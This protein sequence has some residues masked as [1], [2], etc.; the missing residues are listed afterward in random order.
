MLRGESLLVVNWWIDEIYNTHSDCRVHSGCIIILGKGVALN[1][2]PK[3]KLNVKRS[4]EWYLV[5]AHNGLSVV[6]WRNNFMEAQGCT[7]EQNNLY[8]YN[9]SNILM[10]K[11]GRAS[12]SKR[13]EHI[14]ARYF[15]IKD[16]IIQGYAELKYCST[17]KIQGE[18]AEKTKTRQGF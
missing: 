6:L 1:F 5:R 14:K 18:R 13:T 11:N 12:V 8:Q 15:F 7:V 4:T 3:Q 10:E 17:E 2:S 16:Q 9:N